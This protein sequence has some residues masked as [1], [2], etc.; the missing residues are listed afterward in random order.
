M[1]KNLT[2]WHLKDSREIIENNRAYNVNLVLN[3]AKKIFL[4]IKLS[5]KKEY[6]YPTS[7]ALRTLIAV[8]VTHVYNKVRGVANWGH[9]NINDKTI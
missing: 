9:H 5:R 2:W 3:H 8:I 1:R 4:A 7:S 6:L